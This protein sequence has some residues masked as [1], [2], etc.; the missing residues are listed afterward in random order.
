MHVPGRIWLKGCQT[1]GGPQPPV[2]ST[3]SPAYCSESGRNT[4]LAKRCPRRASRILVRM[5]ESPV[6]VLALSVCG[7]GVRAAAEDQKTTADHDPICA[8]HES[9]CQSASVGN[10][11]RGP[12]QSFGRGPLEVVGGLRNKGEGR[13]GGGVLSRLGTLATTAA[14]RRPGLPSPGGWIS[15]GSARIR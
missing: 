3:R 6:A 11:S 10:G 12:Q 9:R 1:R 5:V 14:C 15:A 7:F 13:T 4:P 2:R 8:K